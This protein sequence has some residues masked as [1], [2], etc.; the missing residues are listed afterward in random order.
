MPS[1]FENL[2]DLNLHEQQRQLLKLQDALADAI[3]PHINTLGQPGKLSAGEIHRELF[4]VMTI[5]AQIDAKR[6]GD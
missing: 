5:V 6:R 1:P 2:D 3:H 4:K